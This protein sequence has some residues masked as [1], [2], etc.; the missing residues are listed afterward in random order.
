MSFSIVMI[1]KDKWAVLSEDLHKICFHTIKKKEWE[2]IDFALAA[3]NDEKNEMISYITCKELDHESLYWQYGGVLPAYQKT[4]NS[5]SSYGK[6][7]DW[8]RN[9]GYKRI[10]T[11]IENTNEQMLKMAAHNGFIIIGIRNF[12]GK[13]LLEH[14]IEL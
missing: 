6:A 14:G 12:K 1:P 2:R 3:I 7:F 13:V 9:A 4:F 5:A 10:G 8:C 11:L